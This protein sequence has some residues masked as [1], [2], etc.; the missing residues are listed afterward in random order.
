MTVS[1]DRSIIF[2]CRPLH[3]LNTNRM[4]D[5]QGD[6]CFNL[7]PLKFHHCLWVWLP[8][9]IKNI[10]I[11]PRPVLGLWSVCLCAA[12]TWK[13]TNPSICTMSEVLPV[14]CVMWQM[15]SNGYLLQPHLNPS[16]SGGWNWFRSIEQARHKHR[17]GAFNKFWIRSNM[18]KYNKIR[19]VACTLEHFDDDFFRILCSIHLT[20]PHLWHWVD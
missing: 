14:K 16:R 7:E 5:V 9:K 8:T 10:E 12:S 15:Q 20:P 2:H 1:I 4:G 19:N 13:N 11:V 18:A 6:M 3:A 17:S